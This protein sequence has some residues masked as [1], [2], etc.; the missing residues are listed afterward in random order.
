MKKTRRNT[1]TAA[2]LLLA[3]ISSATAEETY[4]VPSGS[5]TG[6]IDLTAMKGYYADRVL[7]PAAGATA[8][9]TGGI[10]ASSAANPFTIYGDGGTLTFMDSSKLETLPL[11]FTNADGNE[12]ETNVKFTSP[13]VFRKDVSIG[14]KMKVSVSGTS[15]RL[16]GD[17]MNDVPKIRIDGKLYSSVNVCVGYADATVC[18]NAEAV[19]GK[20]GDV[21]MD[22][23]RD[24]YV[25]KQEA[26]LAEGFTPRCSLTVEGKLICRTLYLSGGLDVNASD[27]TAD[28][29]VVTNRGTL[30]VSRV[31]AAAGGW[32]TLVFDGGSLTAKTEVDAIFQATGYAYSYSAGK[33]VYLVPYLFVTCTDSNPLDLTLET[34]RN[35]CSGYDYRPVKFT[36]AG[37]LVKRG[38]GILTFTHNKST[39]DDISTRYDIT[40]ATTVKGGGIKI[41]DDWFVPGRGALVLEAAGTTYDLNGVTALEKNAF[42]GATGLGSI[43][44]T[45]NV[46]ATV[47]FGYGNESADLNVAI[48]ERVN[49][50]KIGTGT[51]TVGANASAF[52]GDLTVAGGT[53][54]LAADLANLGQVVV[55]NGATLDVRG[56]AFG[57][58]S[59]VRCAGATILADEKSSV[60]I[61][62]ADAG[63][64][65]LPAKLTAFEK[66]GAG[67]MTAWGACDVAD[68]VTVSAGTLL[69]RPRD[70][71]GKFYRI[72]LYANLGYPKNTLISLAEFTFVDADG[73]RIDIPNCFWNSIDGSSKKYGNYDGIDDASTLAECETQLW[74]KGSSYCEIVKDGEG[75][76]NLFDNVVSTSHGWWNYWDSANIVVRLPSA[77]ATVAGYKMTRAGDSNAPLTWSLEGSTDGK[78]WTMLDDKRIW[79]LT[80]ADQLAAAT[81]A[82]PAQKAE[83]NGGVPYYLSALTN[84]TNFA[85]F[86]SLTPVKVASGATY[87]AV[88]PTTKLDAL[89]VDFG[90][91]GKGVVSNFTVVANGELTV[92]N[93]DKSMGVAEVPLTFCDMKG[94]SNFKTWKI[95][96]D[97][98]TPEGYTVRWRDGKLYVAPKQG[99]LLIVR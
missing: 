51:L 33:N 47:I 69:V 26:A 57:C 32:N 50:R 67:T 61:G 17:G 82:V 76:T 49:V 90:A 60:T 85:P 21:S 62:G 65:S 27:L 88:D 14:E 42:T 4:R 15:F 77:A 39:Q 18:G 37:G 16:A 63:E 93:Y 10:T 58:A 48:G 86:G 81:N 73:N 96:V 80:D 38:A 45:S 68:G 31:Q 97:G 52:A 19:I 11:A 91:T 12:T 54:K 36:G 66:T 78:E 87:A 84:N 44:N 7:T 29:T 98:V 23:N 5:T 34:D 25:F 55:T 72:M 46:L 30:N 35:L 22:Y 20:T 75:P 89:S 3:A 43:V 2:A 94:T 59:L 24:F 71:D 99:L 6:G 28:T 8:E 95:L 9:V 41:V 64:M 92:A 70:Y 79:D 13:D 83:Y 40:G 53:V 74:G 56:H 1:L